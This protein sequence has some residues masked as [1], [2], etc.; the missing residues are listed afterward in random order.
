MIKTD[1]AVRK[2]RKF[3]ISNKR[4]PTYGEMSYLFHYK[5]KHGAYDLA[6]RLISEGVLIKDSSGKL[7]PKRLFLPLTL[8]GSIKAGYPAPAEDQL[9]ES[10]DS[11]DVYLVDNPEGSFLLKVSGESM[12]DAG[13]YDGDI[14]VVDKDKRPKRGDIVVAHIDNEW[15]LK[16]LDVEKGK[17]CL[18]PANKK[19]KTIYPKKTLVIGGVVVSSVRKY[20]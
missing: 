7:L 8:Y 6:T 12:I 15:T 9:V 5:S 4:L 13:L 14:V 10:L 11:F 1:E 20:H 3:Y 17:P 16:Y 2:I 18:K 19:F